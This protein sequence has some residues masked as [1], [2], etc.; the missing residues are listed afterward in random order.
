MKFKT[1]PLL[2][3]NVPRIRTLHYTW[4]AFFITFII[5]FAAA[6]LMPM[7]KEYFDLTDAQV[8]ALLMLN[9]AITIPTRI[10]VGVLVDKYGPRKSYSFLLAF[11]GALCLLFAAAQSF[12]WL[13][14]TRFLL[15]SV[16]AGFV[17]GIRLVSEWFPAR[18]VGIAEGIYG[19]WGNFGA[20]VASMSLPAL[21]LAFGGT[22]AGATP[23]PAPASSPLPTA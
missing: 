13:A 17:I 5:W 8:K 11:C 15:G 20:A 1:L 6:P 16:G 14:V 10:L 2:S 19:G 7:M 12:E 3:W 22:T 23:L 18:E 9:V 4:M 21:A